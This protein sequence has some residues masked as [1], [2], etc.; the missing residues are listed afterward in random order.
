MNPYTGEETRTRIVAIIKDDE[1]VDQANSG[2]SVE[3]VTERTGFYIE[4]GGQVSDQGQIVTADGQGKF[5]VEEMRQ[6]LCRHD[7]ALRQGG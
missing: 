3:V 7:R 5:A 2:D 6:T 1:L 4:S